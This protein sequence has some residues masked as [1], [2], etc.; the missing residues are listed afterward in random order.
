MAKHIHVHLH[1]GK[2]RD[3][4]VYSEYEK[5]ASMRGKDKRSLLTITAFVRATNANPN[6]ENMLRDRYMKTGDAYRGT[7]TVEVDED[8]YDAFSPGRVVNWMGQNAKV[9]K[10]TLT[11]KK[12][13]GTGELIPAKLIIQMETV[14]CK[15]TDSKLEDLERQLDEIETQIEKME[16]SGQSPSRGLLDKRKQ[17]QGAIAVIKSAPKKAQD[18]GEGELATAVE[19]NPE[20]VGSRAAKRFRTESEFLEALK[21]AGMSPSESIVQRA[22]KAY[23]MAK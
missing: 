16:D 7:F 6:V 12:K 10:R 13:S 22:L 17:I 23:R 9:L 21:R 3:A 14:D 11:E 20:D 19:Q 8:R 18:G 15:A 1:R 2:A 5:W 4:D